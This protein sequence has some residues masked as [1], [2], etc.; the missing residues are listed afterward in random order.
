MKEAR[1]TLGYQ[2]QL[3]SSQTYQ[4]LPH[5]VLFTVGLEPSNSTLCSVSNHFTLCQSQTIDFHLS[6]L[7]NLGHHRKLLSF[8]LPLKIIKILKTHHSRT[9]SHGLSLSLSPMHR[10]PASTHRPCLLEFGQIVVTVTETS[11]FIV[12]YLRPVLASMY[13]LHL[14]SPDPLLVLLWARESVG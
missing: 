2:A 8:Y 13:P 7:G 9:P 10:P 1:G 3:H 14:L 6:L 12:Y 5:S 4:D 11:Q